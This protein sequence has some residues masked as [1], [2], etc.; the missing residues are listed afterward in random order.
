MAAGVFGSSKCVL[1]VCALAQSDLATWL[2]FLALAVDFLN[3]IVVCALQP[4]KFFQVSKALGSI[5][6]IASC[7]LVWANFSFSV[8]LMLST[9]SLCRFLEQKA[10]REINTLISPE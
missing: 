1:F 5:S 6:F 4:A 2:L 9:L 10:L 7:L 8:A 3:Y